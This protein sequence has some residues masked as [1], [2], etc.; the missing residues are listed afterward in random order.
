MKYDDGFVA[1]LNGE[2]ATSSRAP[3]TPVWNSEATTSH[4]D[5]QA[6]LFE[7]FDISDVIG[8]L[9]NGRNV[10]GIHG[11][12]LNPTS[13][14]MLILPEIV[15]REASDDP[16]QQGNRITLDRTSRIRARTLLNTTWSALNEALY[17]VDT[18]SLRITEL[19]YN[20]PADAP[21]ALFGNDQYE[22]VELQNTGD[23]PLNLAGV[24]FTAGIEF[25]FP[26]SPDPANDLQPGETVLIVR[27]L[28]AFESRYDTGSPPGG[29]PALRIAG[30]YEGALDNDGDLVVL[31]DAAGRVLLDFVY[32]DV[33]YPL[34]DGAGR[35]LE[36]IDQTDDPDLWR[37]LEGWR[38]SE[39]VGGSPGEATIIDGGLQRGG[40]FNQDSSLDIADAIGIV[41]Y[42][43]LGVPAVLP[44]E[45]GTASD[46]G[47]IRLL[48]ANGD[49]AIDFS[50]AIYL[51]RFL[52]QRGP[53]PHLGTNCVRIAG[54]PDSCRR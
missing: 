13:G 48:D 44:C 53:L 46:E 20:P 28:E 14:D 37:R 52:F 42:L 22:F 7:D 1:Y 45:G 40:D 50:D 11:L 4:A 16:K 24:R 5:N 38:A 19:M 8:S 12:N 47:N 35:S 9:R 54:C 27:N 25:A 32:S 31:E 2:L 23:V 34:T 39:L 36:I 3:A 15:A 49:E 51:M 21:P 41:R 17:V 10:L 18:S 29:G 26:D 33:W 30:E 6:I 43:F